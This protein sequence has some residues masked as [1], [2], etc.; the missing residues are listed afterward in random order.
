MKK[1][2]VSV[3]QK[4]LA[5][6]S[7]RIVPVLIQEPSPHGGWYALNLKTKQHIRI[8]SAARLRGPAPALSAPIDFKSRAAGE[9]EEDGGGL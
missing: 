4:Y 1:A 9:H 6:V 5:K 3:G 8:K 2:A 7:G